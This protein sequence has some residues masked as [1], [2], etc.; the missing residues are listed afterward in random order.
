MRSWQQKGAVFLPPTINL[1]RM[2][3]NQYDA[4]F[5]GADRI[6]RVAHLVRDEMFR[7]LS[8]SFSGSGGIC[9]FL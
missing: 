6:F 3:Y 5:K 7:F 1:Y 8:V 2:M 4:D 9:N